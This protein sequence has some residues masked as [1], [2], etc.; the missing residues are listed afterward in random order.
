MRERNFRLY[1]A[2]LLW[3]LVALLFGL[4]SV[5][6]VRAYPLTGK[7]HYLNGLFEACNSSDPEIVFESATRYISPSMPKIVELMNLRYSSAAP[8][9]FY[10]GGD[11]H[12]SDPPACATV[13]VRKADTTILTYYVRLL[14]V[15]DPDTLSTTQ[16]I[17]VCVGFTAL[18]GVGIVA[19][20]QR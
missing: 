7:G 12:V 18:F 11:A 6:D 20:Q 1:V 16:L 5:Q 2:W 13:Q 3:C 8:F 10:S 14:A 9:T 15:D 17:L 19:G 4:S